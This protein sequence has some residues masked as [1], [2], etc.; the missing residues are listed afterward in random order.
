MV[1][2]P[3]PDDEALIGSGVL[4]R[5]VVDGERVAV[6]VMTNGDY[7]C[8][9]DGLVRE[10]ESV[11]AMHALGIDEDHLYFLGFPD[12]SLSK[13]GQSPLASRRIVDGTCALGNTTYGQHGFGRR[14]YHAATTGSPTTY[15]RDHA[16]SDL[17]SIL[18]ALRPLHV[19]VTH[20]EDTHPDHAA[21]YALLRDALERL[22][23]APTLHR[24]IVHNGDCW[25]TGIESHEP[26]PP[27]G[28]VVT[29]ALPPL[30]GRLSGYTPPERIV[31]P[32]ACRSPNWETNPKLRA[33]AAYASQTRS[34]HESYLFSFARVDEAFF[35]ESFTRAGSGWMR[36][37]SPVLGPP[38]TL[39]FQAGTM[40]SLSADLP[41]SL[42]TRLVR[43]GVGRSNRASVRL[44]VAL[45]GGGEY[46]LAID[47]GAGEAT[48]SR[49][50]V[51]HVWPLPHDLWRSQIDEPFELS[52]DPRPED[53]AVTEITLRC[54]G[55]TV[56]VAIDTARAARTRGI[57]FEG[58]LGAPDGEIVVR[59][60]SARSVSAFPSA[61][62][63]R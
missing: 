37:G 56:G 52:I 19:A 34:S 32:N 41:L 13:L 30:S 46:V 62:P 25:P 28:L 5:A 45:E 55:A 53:G 48:L 27:G 36:S 6:V 35:P 59:A 20:P 58:E 14:D 39:R 10:R 8:V 4:H 21:T 63:A 40:L 31:V 9:V 7:D 42:A 23:E 22:P 29:E 17:V 16:V 49:E 51:L 50:K 43:P 18:G 60:S 12:G 15:T 11:S 44:D 26:C 47:A 3:H 2:A 54:R 38:R 1:I 57:K 33:I 24:A 61:R